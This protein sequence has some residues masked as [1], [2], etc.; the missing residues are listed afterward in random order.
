MTSRANWSPGDD[1]A[2]RC[3]DRRNKLRHAHRYV[4]DAPFRRIRA[5]R[6]AGDLRDLITN[7]DNRWLRRREIRRYGVD[8][9]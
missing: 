9:T 2:P 1:E 3:H 4:P 8:G 6:F 5:K 7:R